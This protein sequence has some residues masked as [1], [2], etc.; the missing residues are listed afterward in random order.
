VFIIAILPK[1]GAMLL[2]IKVLNFFIL[3]L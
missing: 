1:F 2:L 3:F